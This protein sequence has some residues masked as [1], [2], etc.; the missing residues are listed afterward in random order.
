[1]VPKIDKASVQS[2][3]KNPQLKIIG[4][5]NIFD[6]NDFICWKNWR[7]LIFQDKKV[8]NLVK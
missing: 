2:M 8:S 4:R 1:M 7:K 3:L 6:D 5:K